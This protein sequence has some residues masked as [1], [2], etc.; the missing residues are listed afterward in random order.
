MFGKAYVHF[1]PVYNTCVGLEAKRRVQ[2][3]QPLHH[4]TS[5]H[6]LPVLHSASSYAAETLAGG[7][8]FDKATSMHDV[9]YKRRKST[10]TDYRKTGDVTPV[11]SLST[12]CCRSVTACAYWKG[13]LC[14]RLPPQQ[15]QYR[16]TCV[17]RS[18]SACPYLG[19]FATHLGIQWMV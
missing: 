14:F 13:L 1:Q 16:S 3:L 10:Q 7:P 17:P 8:T 18:H 19:T 15:Q 2:L 5:T 6:G 11:L 4:S 12:D 9:L